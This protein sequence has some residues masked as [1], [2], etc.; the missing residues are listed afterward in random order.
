LVTVASRRLA[1]QLRS[2]A[3]RR[4]REEADAIRTPPPPAGDELYPDLE[5]R[6]PTGDDTLTL[7]FLCC[8]PALTPPSQVLA[9]H[10]GSRV[11]DGG[12]LRLAS[13]V[14]SREGVCRRRRVSRSRG[15]W[16][17]AARRL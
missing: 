16:P 14:R 10:K 13:S 1:D 8:H 3:A 4:R 11:A 5:A 6:G 2:D 17:L 9:V 7:L 12:G 15:G